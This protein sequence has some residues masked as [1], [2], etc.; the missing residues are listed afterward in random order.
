M[1]RPS[2][3]EYFM[4]IAFLAATRSNCVRR[5]VGAVIVKEKRI[6]STGYNGPPRGS[7]H[8]DEIGCLREQ[9]KIPSGERRELCRGLHAEQNAI[10]QAAYNG[11]AIN[12][13]IIYVTTHP[14]SDC[15]KMI[16][17]AGIREII[18]SEGY[19]DE[20]SELMLIESNITTRQY[21]VSPEFKNLLFGSKIEL[22]GKEE[23]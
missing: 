23:D 12:G 17:N 16:I 14:C 3:D 2:W 10:I 5:K 6:I 13:S 20:L 22:I 19:P 9:L 7:L 8:C 18:F 11:T 15:S 4:R 1:E 21:D